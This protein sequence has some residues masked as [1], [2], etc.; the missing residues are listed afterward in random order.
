MKLKQWEESDRQNPIT[1]A[2][3]IQATKE[4]VTKYFSGMRVLT[5]SKKIIGYIKV[6]TKIPFY[7]TKSDN[8]V[9][10]WLSKNKVFLRQ[11]TLSQNRHANVGWLLYLHPEYTNQRLAVHDLR[12]RMTTRKLEFEVVPHNIVH[13]TRDNVKISTRALKV[14]TNFNDKDEVI[15]ELMEALKKGPLDPK[16]VC[17]SNTGMFKFIPFGKATFNTNQMTQLIKKQNTFLHK[18]HAISVV[19]M[20]YLDGVFRDRILLNKKKFTKRK[21]RKMKKF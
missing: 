4:E 15:K 10:N 16:L 7:C 13:T 19:N 18:T 21:G 14:R 1:K 2:L 3:D 8:R 20:R 17:T 6:E 9:F 12:S 5:N 11:T